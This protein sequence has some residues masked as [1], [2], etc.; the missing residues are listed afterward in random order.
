MSLKLARAHWVAADAIAWSHV[1]DGPIV[2][3]HHH[4]DGGLELAAAGVLGGSSIILTHDPAGLPAAVI[5]KLPHLAALPVWRIAPADL[6]VVPAILKG[7][8]V[9][10][11]TTAGGDLVDAT[12]LQI[13]GVLDDLYAYDGPLGVTFD[14]GASRP[15]ASGRR[16]P[17]RSS[18]TCSPTRARRP[19]HA[20][21][22]LP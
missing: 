3:L 4:P 14:H 8:A 7:Q 11:A 2:R 6:P 15:C 9:V 20:R 16:P 12:A 19:R 18:S 22:V 10:S 1:V 21:H 17:G 13:P 5:A